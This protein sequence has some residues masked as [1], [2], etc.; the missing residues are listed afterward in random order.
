M[1]EAELKSIS[2][3]KIDLSDDF[4][5]ILI[6]PDEPKDKTVA[7]LRKIFKQKFSATCDKLASICTENFSK[8]EAD[9]DF[10]FKSLA[11]ERQKKIDHQILET[12][13]LV[14]NLNAELDA[15]E[16]MRVIAGYKAQNKD[17]IDLGLFFKN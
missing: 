1:V 7:E 14:Q 2:A 3:M 17:E 8:I 10:K 9:L 15:G 6:F 16:K 12:Q 5:P 11:A 13:Q 4:K